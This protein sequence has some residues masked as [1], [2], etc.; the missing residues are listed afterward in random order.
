MPDNSEPSWQ[1]KIRR[2]LQRY[3]GYDGFLPLQAEA[4][5]CV[6]NHRDTVVVLP[7]GGGKSLCFQAPAMCQDGLAV[8]VSP[9]ISLMKDQVDGLRS[10]GVPAAAL[11]GMVDDGERQRIDDAIRA[12]ELRLLYVAPER[13]LQELTLAFLKQQQISFFAIDEAHCIS[14]WGHDF[15]PEYRQLKILKEAFPGVAVHAYTATATARVRQDIAAQ[16]GLADAK[17]LVGP[18]DRPNLVYKVRRRADRLR[19]VREVLD[20]HGG[21]SG[22]IYCITRKEV[23]R[24]CLALT[25]A[26]YLVRPYHAG[27]GDEERRQNQEAFIREEVDTIVATVAFGMG[28]DKSNVRYVIHAGMPKS[29]EHYQQESGRA[30]RDGL[31]AECAL[32]FSGQDFMTWKLMLGNMPPES[33]AGALAALSAMHRFCTSVSCRHRALVEYFGEQYGGGECGACDVCLH[34]LDLVAEPLVIGQKILSCVV[35]L[36]QRFGGEYTAMVLNGSNDKRIL[37]QRHNELS[38]WGIL[39]DENKRTIRD[40]VEQLVDQDFLKKTGEYNVLQVTGTGRRLLKGEVAPQLLQPAKRAPVRTKVEADSWEGVDR[41]LFEDLRQL[42]REIAQERNVAAYIIFSDAALRDMA[43]KQP[44]TLED[45]LQ[46]KG[47]G[48]QKRDDYGKQFL[49]CI[50]EKLRIKAERKSE[51]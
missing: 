39:A 31:P 24:T 18:V 32:F 36:Q 1:E 43:R 27:L 47:V 35:R 37:R 28:I 45:F 5:A 40:W 26:G 20:R 29:L 12:R 44:V 13:L 21:D 23:D 6:L 2:V 48:E 33:Q 41:D 30:G 16:L 42:R 8:V 7:T 22:I 25:E 3:W 14:A 10:C 38:T 19:Q 51:K 46:V 50:A 17:I 11:H 4:M 49:A 9:L 34:E 15:R